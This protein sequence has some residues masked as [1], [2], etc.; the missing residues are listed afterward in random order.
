MENP[1]SRIK[2]ESGGHREWGICAKVSLYELSDPFELDFHFSDPHYTLCFSNTS[3]TP[4]SSYCTLSNS[5]NNYVPIFNDTYSIIYNEYGRL[6]I[7]HYQVLKIPG[8]H[9]FGK[10]RYT[11]HMKV[12]HI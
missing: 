10:A 7:I 1:K 4:Y 6:Y 11:I 3:D 8:E 2:K 12:T 9:T 5:S